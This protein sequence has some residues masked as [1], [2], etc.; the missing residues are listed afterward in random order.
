[1]TLTQDKI[2]AMEDATQG[3]TLALQLANTID[4]LADPPDLLQDLDRF[5]RFLRRVGYGGAGE[6]T[7][8]DLARVRALRSRITE[9]MDADEVTAAAILAPMAESLDT[10]PRLV[11]RRGGGWDL[12]YGPSP[13]LGAPAL[14]G[15]VVV[16]LMQLLADGQWDRIGRCTGSPCCCLFVDRTRNRNRRFCC[17][18]C[19]DRTNQARARARRRPS[20][21]S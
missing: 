11:P 14:A 18:L 10:R 3:V 1:M 4:Q 2:L 7:G 21:R 5:T 6:A 15:S 19:A 9:A 17:Q 8:R 20:S 13:E 16:G 12:R